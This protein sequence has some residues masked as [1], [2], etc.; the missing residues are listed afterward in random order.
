MERENSR[1]CWLQDEMPALPCSPS[2]EFRKG[3]I[4]SFQPALL[5]PGIERLEQQ[6]VELEIGI[7]GALAK[8]FA[9]A[10]R[11]LERQ[12]LKIGCL[13]RRLGSA[14][15]SRRRRHGR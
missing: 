10:R 15:R 12:R 6:L 4:L 8:A 14:Q 7:G 2:S 3:R 5:F 11:N 9:K 1:L 13:R